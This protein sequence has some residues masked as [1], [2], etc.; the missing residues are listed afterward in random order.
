[1]SRVR[2]GD[3]YSHVVRDG[4]N[5]EQPLGAR[6]RVIDRD[7]CWGRVFERHASIAHGVVPEHTSGIRGGRA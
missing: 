1:M 7:R 2:I 3:Q 6:G 5:D 4:M